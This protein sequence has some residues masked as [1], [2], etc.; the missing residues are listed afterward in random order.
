MKRDGQRT[1]L[2]LVLT[3]LAVAMPCAAWYLVGS[4]EADRQ[5]TSLTEVVQRNTHDTAHRL[6]EQLTQRLNALREA[7]SRRPFYHYQSFFHDPK[8]AS[9][10]ASVVPSP[11]ATGPNDPLVEVY[12]QADAA[13]GRVTVPS[14]NVEVLKQLEEVTTQQVRAQ[15][16]ES[17]YL[18]RELERGLASILFVLQSETKKTAAAPQQRV[19][20]MQQQ[21]YA[22]NVQASKLYGELRAG[23]RDNLNLPAQTKDENVQVTIGALKWRTMYVAGKPS[24]VALRDVTTPQGPQLQGFLISARGLADFFRTAS[25]PARLTPGAVA[26]DSEAEVKVGDEPWRVVVDA[27]N[28]LATAQRKA[29]G[30]RR[31]FLRIFAGGVA[32]ATLAGLCVV[33][34]VW[35][36][37]RLA[38]QRSQFAASAAHEL[39][40]PLA[41]LRIYSE[42]LAEGLGE[43]SKAKEY[44]RRV[45][46]E[47]ERL[48]RVV[49]N[50]LGFTRLERGTMKV[51]IETGDLAGAVREAVAR[52]QPALE[53]AGARL[54]VQIVED[55]PA[56]KFDRDAVAQILQ[57]LLDNAEKHTR[58][59][60]DRCI[61]VALATS[62]RNI[63]LTVSDRGPGVLAETQ[64]K[65]F[66]PFERG[67]H[68][69][70]PAGL[71]LGLVLVKALAEAQG[72]R[73]SYRDNDGVG[74]RFTVAF[75]L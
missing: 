8:G 18:Q 66:Q 43:P 4:R 72:A 64:R 67:N 71:G 33:G 65:L 22:Q 27:G 50:V 14:A 70:A 29:A 9:E 59:A 42:M 56:V 12:F 40:T 48:G 17:R 15:L 75:P 30:V 57:N 6:A 44:A 26:G 32:I 28:S 37:E 10:G 13:S 47:A 60:S 52:Q 73:V 34:L 51:H 36:S 63:T 61:Q 20:K 5:A 35:Q 58:Q 69:D 54:E 11:L 46:D 23:Q 16:D 31:G 25:L 62:D 38:R 74:A 3:V 24:L 41:G 53:A 68:A 21:A 49:A 39:R 1:G 55:L 2:A 19:E 7:E 45:A